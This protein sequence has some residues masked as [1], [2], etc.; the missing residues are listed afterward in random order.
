M[1]QEAEARRRQDLRQVM[2]WE[3]AVPG[4]NKLPGCATA[5]TPCPRGPRTNVSHPDAKNAAG[6]GSVTVAVSFG[7]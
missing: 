5:L 6:V 4:P 2:I 3:G 7:S 1:D